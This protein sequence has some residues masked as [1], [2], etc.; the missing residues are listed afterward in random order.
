MTES[1]D[2]QHDDNP[3]SGGRPVVSAA[4]RALLEDQLYKWARKWEA[5]ERA[6]AYNWKTW[7][8]GENDR[9]SNFQL[10]TPSPL[11]A[12]R[13]TEAAASFR[14][15]TASTYDG[16]HVSHFRILGTEAM[17]TLVGIL[18]CIEHVG[19]LPSQIR[20]SKMLPLPKA[21]LGL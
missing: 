8:E 9:D 12:E 10:V 4:P 1:D 18:N 5:S 3:R 13:L 20:A 11:D 16:F 6:F 19:S 14:T 2:E 17:S 21:K 7:H 15:T